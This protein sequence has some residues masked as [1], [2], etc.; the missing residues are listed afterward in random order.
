MLT[1]HR[2]SSTVFTVRLDTKC[3]NMFAIIRHNWF[4]MEQRFRTAPPL[5]MAQWRSAAPGLAVAFWALVAGGCRRSAAV[6]STPCRL[7]SESAGR[8]LR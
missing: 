5:R 6:R 2:R 1:L 4:H 3:C 8:P 7:I